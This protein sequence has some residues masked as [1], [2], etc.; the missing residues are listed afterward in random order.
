MLLQIKCDLLV[1][2]LV[3]ESL[4]VSFRKAITNVK[5]ATYHKE[6]SLANM[7][8]EMSA[9]LFREC[10][11]EQ[12]FEFKNKFRILLPSCLVHNNLR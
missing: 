6:V 2:I 11:R 9:V 4:N 7:F 8:L 10:S 5:Q 1:T 12:N 3:F